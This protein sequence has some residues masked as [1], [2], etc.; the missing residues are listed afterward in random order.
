MTSLLAREI[1]EQPRVLG[2]VL[3][4]QGDAL[5][6][7]RECITQHRRVLLLGIGSSRHV[8]GY[9]VA[10]FEALTPV[11]VSL[12]PAPG[13]GVAL[14]A[15]TPEDVLVVV[16][17]SGSTPALQPV[18]ET[19]LA[20]GAAYDRCFCPEGMGRQVAAIVA[21]PSR[22]PELARLDVPTLVLHGSR[23]RLVDPSGGRHT[24]EVI[25]GA[26][27][28]EI[29]GMG[30]DYPPAVW[31]TWVRTWADFAAPHRTA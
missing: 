31:D 20:A 29:E 7:V 16:S 12:L 21:G 4:A 19:A 2:S 25:P 28:V 6:A 14:P 13:A 10:C 11:P 5:V 23:D 24:A 17:Q 26:R 15:L 30:H 8:A 18:V 9:G 22:D 3:D 27:Y 1:A